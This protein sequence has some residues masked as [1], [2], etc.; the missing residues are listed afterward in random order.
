MTDY[1]TTVHTPYSSAPTVTNLYAKCQVC[2][3]SWQVR[4]P[5]RGDAKGCS[6]CDAP[7][8]AITVVSEKPDFGG[9]TVYR[10][11]A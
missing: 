3:T 10:G 2:G 4:S 1:S 7:E 6:F 8:S 11:M 9:A 5:N